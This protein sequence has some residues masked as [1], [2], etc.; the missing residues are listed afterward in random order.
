VGN[1]S[2]DGIDEGIFIAA[3]LTARDD[4]EGNFD[5]TF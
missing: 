5:R 2:K 3:T 1:L 4:V